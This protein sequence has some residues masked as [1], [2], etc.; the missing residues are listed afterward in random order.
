[1]IQ[2]DQ[3]N[4]THYVTMD[5]IDVITMIMVE[6]IYTTTNK[7]A[8]ILTNLRN[9]DLKVKKCITHYTIK[10]WHLYAKCVG[11]TLQSIFTMEACLVSHVELSFVVQFQN[12]TC[13]YALVTNDA[14]LASQLEKI[15]NIVDIMHA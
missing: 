14:Q 7:L 15:V 12:L 2:Q 6:L 8:Q 10:S 9:L 4:M 3:D 1:M 13:M 11:I 5:H